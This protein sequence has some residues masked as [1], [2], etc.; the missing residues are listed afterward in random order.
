MSFKHVAIRHLG[1]IA[2]ASGLAGLAAGRYGGAGSIFML[3]SIVGDDY[4]F[5]KENVQTSAGFLEKIIRHCVSRRIAVVSLSDAMLRIESGSSERFVC[6]TFDDGYRDNLKIALPIFRKYQLP[7]TVFVTSAFLDRRPVEYWWGQLRYLV[8]DHSVTVGDVLEERLPM[9]SIEEKRRAYKR[10]KGWINS[11][12]I[13][14]VALEKLFEQHRVPVSDCL[15][16]DAFSAREL[17]EASK[18]PLLE[19]GG[20]TV[21][22]CQLSRLNEQSALED[23]KQNKL[24]L[25]NLIEREVQHFCYPFGDE[26]SCGEREFRLAEAAGFKTAVTSRIGN[27]FPDHLRHRFALP[28]LRFLGPCEGLGFM[29]SQRYGAITALQTRFGNPVRVS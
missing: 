5:P 26:A 10:I 7:F 4:L 13:G 16:R 23:M 12:T 24:Q 20:H 27:L 15:D 18:E 29:E 9:T 21:S 22:H 3:H 1:N 2:A 11:G 19:I 8:M 25:E 17:V 28:R 14:P 6:F